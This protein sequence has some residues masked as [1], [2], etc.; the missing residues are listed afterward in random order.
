MKVG[1]S[2]PAKRSAERAIRA[3]LTVTKQCIQDYTLCQLS[4]LFVQGK[5]EPMLCYD[6]YM[7]FDS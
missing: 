4:N 2:C 1:N 3:R 7:K 5:N 6:L